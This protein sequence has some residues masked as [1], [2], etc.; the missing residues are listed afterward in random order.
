MSYMP[1]TTLVLVDRHPASPMQRT[2]PFTSDSL[3]H[4]HGLFI[5]D[6]LSPAA[7]Y[8]SVFGVSGLV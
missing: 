2:N 7:A 1:L 3:M 4:V 8:A 6:S 5:I